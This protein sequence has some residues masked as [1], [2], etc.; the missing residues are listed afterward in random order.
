MHEYRIIRPDGEIRWLMNQT[1]PRKDHQGQITHLLGITFDITDIKNYECQLKTTNNELRD[2]TNALH[3][4]A[5]VTITDTNGTITY[6][7]DKFC[8]ISKYSREELIGQNHRL[9]KSGYHSEEVYQELWDTISQGQV[10]HKEVKNKAKDGTYFWS[11][12]TIVPFLNED[13]VPYQ[14]IAIRKDI[15]A[16]KENEEIIRKL[17]FEDI[18]TQLPNIRSLENHLDKLCQNKENKFAVLLIGLDHFKSIN[19]HYGMKT[20]DQVLI[21]VSKRLERITREQNGFISRCSGDEFSI[22]LEGSNPIEQATRLA[23]QILEIINRPIQIKD[24]ILYITATIGIS[25]FPMDGN[26]GETLLEK[27]DIA[28]NKGKSSGKNRSLFFTNVMDIESFKYFTLRNDLN[29]AIGEEDFFIQYQPKVDLSTNQVIGAEA[30]VRWEHP[31]WGTVPPFE[32]ISIAE[33]TGLI[34]KLGEWIFN[35][36]C[37][38]IHEW[39][40]MGLR[41]IPISINFSPRQFLDPSL[42]D[43]ILNTINKSDIDP[44]YLEIEITENFIFENYDEVIKKMT[45]LRDRGISFSIDDFGTGYSSLKT[46][47]KLHFDF[48]KI[49]RSFIKDLHYS[50]ESLQ[51]TK[52]MIQLAHTLDMKVVAEGTENDRQ[53]AILKEQKC[54]Y[55]QGYSFSEAVHA[56]EFEKFLQN[57]KYN[58]ENDHKKRIQENINRRKYFRILFKYPLLASLTVQVVNH[59]PVQIG[60]SSILIEDL[61]AGGLSYQSNIKFPL[62]KGFIL[63]IKTTILD[64]TCRLLGEM[65][66]VKKSIINYTNM[67][68]NLI[69]MNRNEPIFSLY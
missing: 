66:G 47:K 2:I 46:L 32:F 18:L 31:K 25:C 22:I 49:D 48:L 1:F 65:F 39:N 8:E 40:Q 54:D 42:N 29:K 50:E 53:V 6:A 3:L 64:Q 59:K 24:Q 7:N 63:E 38:Q 37:M 27:A 17:A 67:D 20:G 52:A 9:I 28:L 4:T 19:D 62:N 43:M 16:K 11:D 44:N 68:L 21:E 12:S 58:P 55:I 23:K 41:K 13:G 57:G 5:D 36:V 10:W 51:I 26:K 35:Q 45:L 30:L 56:K 34:I 14:Y 61:G 69:W 33:D 60:S 15:T